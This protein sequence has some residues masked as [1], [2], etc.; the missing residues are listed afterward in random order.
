M[1]AWHGER[2]LLVDSSEPMISRFQQVCRLRRAD[3]FRI[4]AGI[5]LPNTASLILEFLLSFFLKWLGLGFAS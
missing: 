5:S 2:A 3:D 4:P 1:S